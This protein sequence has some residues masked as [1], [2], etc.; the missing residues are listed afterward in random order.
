MTKRVAVPRRARFAPAPLRILPL[1]TPIKFM[2]R[3]INC[4]LQFV[5]SDSV[6]GGSVQR[7]GTV[8]LCIILLLL[9]Y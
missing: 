6:R 3:H 8:H 9:F 4:T 1:W 5:N 2:M 7:H